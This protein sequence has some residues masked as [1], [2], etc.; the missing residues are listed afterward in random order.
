MVIHIICICWTWVALTFLKTMNKC[1]KKKKRTMLIHKYSLNLRHK[2]ENAF[3]FW[4]GYFTACNLSYSELQKAAHAYETGKCLC[5]HGDKYLLTWLSNIFWHD[6]G[7][8]VIEI[9]NHD[10]FSR[11]KIEYT[12]RSL[13]TFECCG[14]EFW[15]LATWFHKFTVGVVLLAL[16]WGFRWRSVHFCKHHLTCK[17]RPTAWGKGGGHPVI[18]IL[19]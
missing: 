6:I 5:D 4:G 14:A 13:W 16:S 12:S 1:Q 15:T 7:L 18:L 17:R 11:N 10:R 9:V 2:Q 8:H 3:F 19:F